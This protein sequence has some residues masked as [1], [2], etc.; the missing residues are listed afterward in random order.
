MHIYETDKAF[1][2]SR[3][4]ADI[5]YN[6]NADDAMSPRDIAEMAD[7]TVTKTWLAKLLQGHMP[8][9]HV[10][11]PLMELVADACV[12]GVKGLRAVRVL[13]KMKNCVQCLSQKKLIL[14]S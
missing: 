3:N 5:V 6:I 8:D 9:I 12:L 10:T 4:P 14:C 7:V 11:R 13:K 1:T 2:N